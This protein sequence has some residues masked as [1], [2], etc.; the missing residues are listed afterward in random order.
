MIIKQKRGRKSIV[1]DKQELLCF[2]EEH[3][4]G[5]KMLISLDILNEEDI[6]KRP[7]GLGRNY[8]NANPYLEQ[9]NENS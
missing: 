3:P 1:D 2:S 5:I 8:P 4:Q 9:P 6:M 7:A